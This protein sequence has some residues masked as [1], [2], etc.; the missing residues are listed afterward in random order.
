M[1]E[2]IYRRPQFAVVYFEKVVFLH[3]PLL[4]RS[5]HMFVVIGDCPKDIR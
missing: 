4:K 1:S 3:S 5:V 2:K